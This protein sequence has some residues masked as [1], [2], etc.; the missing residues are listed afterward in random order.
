MTVFKHLVSD[1]EVADFWQ[2]KRRYEEGDIFPFLRET[3]EELT[4]LLA[5]FRSDDYYD[6]I[7]DLHT[8]TSEGNTPVEFVFIEIDAQYLGFLTYKIYHAE[9]GKAFLL[10][11]SIEESLLSQGIGTRVFQD[12]TVFL[13]EQGARYVALNASNTRNQKFWLRQGFSA[14]ETDEQGEVIY[15]LALF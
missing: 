4:E 6:T 12:F 15:T 2:K 11:F 9:D 5:W 10:D 13:K 8:H 14:S 7:M 1:E 3:G